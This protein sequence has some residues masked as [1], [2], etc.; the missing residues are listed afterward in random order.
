MS[1]EFSVR[2]ANINDIDTLITLLKKNAA[3]DYGSENYY[4]AHKEDTSNGFFGKE[5]VAF[6]LLVE[7][8]GI[9]VGLSTYYFTFSSFAGKRKM[10]LDDLFII[11]SFRGNGLGRMMMQSLREIAKQHKCESIE[12]TVA[13]D[14]SNGLLF[15]NKIGATISEDQRLAQLKMD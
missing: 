11:A 3:F 14:N 7:K 10:W 1:S 5:P 4:T 9:P 15:Y 2:N 12:W 6:A 13:K 8:S